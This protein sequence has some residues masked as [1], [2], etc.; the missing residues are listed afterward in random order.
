[1]DA[2][3]VI[4]RAKSMLLTPRPQWPVVAAE[5]D[6]I[7]GIYLNYVFIMAAIPAVARFVSSSLVGVSVPFLGMHRIGVAAGLTVAVLGYALALAG[8]FVL[9]LIVEALAPTFGGEKNRVQALKA[10]AYA[11]TASWVSSIIGI[12]PGLALLAAL[13]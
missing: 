9:A 4:T 11:S 8:V 2:N 12:I 1:M 10:V 5:P 6:T 7:G 3:R 13:A